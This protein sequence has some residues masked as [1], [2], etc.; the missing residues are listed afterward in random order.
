MEFGDLTVTVVTNVQ[1]IIRDAQ[2]MR[3]LSGQ[4]FRPTSLVIRWEGE[5]ITRCSITGPQMTRRGD[6]Y[7][8]GSR[9][10]VSYMR[11]DVGPGIT[12]PDTP[13]WVLEVIRRY[14][15]AS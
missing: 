6:A 12:D 5:T 2:P 3:T 15:P 4:T 11:P 7:L 8:T 13:E 1:L 14:Q 9:K 10:G